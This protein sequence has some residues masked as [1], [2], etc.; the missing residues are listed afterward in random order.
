M[1]FSSNRIV[2][3]YN[4]MQKIDTRNRKHFTIDF[5]YN[6]GKLRLFTIVTCVA[7]DDGCVIQTKSLKL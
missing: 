1:L 6:N 5:Y 2:I 4:A 7:F 3:F